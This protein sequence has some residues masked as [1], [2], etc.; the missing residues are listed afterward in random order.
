[1]RCTPDQVNAFFEALGAIATWSNVRALYTD[2]SALG[3]NWWT[4]CFYSMWGMWNCYFYPALGQWWSFW[5]GI[6]LVAGNLAWIGLY[7][8]QKRS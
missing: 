8:Y 7:A 4:F 2:G 3:V 1:M 5:A 6:V